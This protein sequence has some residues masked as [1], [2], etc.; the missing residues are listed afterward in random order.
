MATPALRSLCVFCGSATG[1]DVKHTAA[2]RILGQRLADAKINLIYGGGR[3]G[4]MGVLAE[5]VVAAGGYA[6]GI[7]PRHLQEAEV[8][9]DDV[10]ELIVVEDMHTRKRAMFDRADAFCV[11]PG[12]LGTLDETF[13]IM[14]WKQLGLHKK[15]IIIANLEGYWSPWLGLIDHVI[16]AGF[17]RP[18]VRG[19]FSVVD[20]IEDILPTVA[21]DLVPPAQSLSALF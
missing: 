2:A 6:V 20:K 16:G 4:L 21:R 13:E 11:L 15:P 9:F 1:N 12:G 14:T 18:S 8:A 17:S 10:S 3:I 7:I 19:L 5:S